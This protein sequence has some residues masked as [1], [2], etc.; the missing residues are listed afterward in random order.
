MQWKDWQTD[1]PTDRPIALAELKHSNI[2]CVLSKTKQNQK[3]ESNNKTQQPHIFIQHRW[4]KEHGHNYHNINID[5]GVMKMMVKM[6]E[7]SEEL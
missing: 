6:Q 5:D 7:T 1:R 2:D 3:E 4:W